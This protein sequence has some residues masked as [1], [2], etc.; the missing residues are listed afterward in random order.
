VW[1]G[2]CDY[3]WHD[4]T[5]SPPPCI[6]SEAA[7]EAE[8]VRREQER[9]EREAVDQK[10]EGACSACA[11]IVLLSV[12]AVCMHSRSHPFPLPCL[13][14]AREERERRRELRKKEDEEVSVWM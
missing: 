2:V 12:C 9:A 1:C 7:R 14:E 4:V 3:A 10:R 8:R 13:A 11:M 5:A 6:H